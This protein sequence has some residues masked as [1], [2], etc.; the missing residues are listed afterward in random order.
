MMAAEIVLSVL[1]T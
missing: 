1:L